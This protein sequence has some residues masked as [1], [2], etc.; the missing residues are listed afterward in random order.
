MKLLNGVHRATPFSSFTGQENAK[1]NVITFFS[2]EKCHNL[3]GH[4]SSKSVQWYGG[5]DE[6]NYTRMFPRGPGAYR[7]GRLMEA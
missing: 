7:D 2:G 1:P 4:Q 6:I 5:N 3:T